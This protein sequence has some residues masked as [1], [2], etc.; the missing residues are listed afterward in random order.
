MSKM[1]AF[2]IGL[3]LLAIILAMIVLTAFIYRAGERSSVKSYIFQTDNNASQ[4]IGTLQDIDDISATVLRNKLIKKYVAEY[5]KVI[6]G[7]K[8]VMNRPTLKIMSYGGNAFDYWKQTEAKTIEEMSN[9][10]MLRLARVRDDGIATYNRTDSSNGDKDTESVY[11]KVRYTTATWVES[12]A[13]ETEPLYDQGT[14]YLE[15]RF[16]PGLSPKI[17][18]ANYDLRNYL[19]AGK[20]PAGLFKFRVINIGDNT[21]R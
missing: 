2:F 6:P 7:D 11:Y 14:L 15:V 19:E 18:G 5:F 9:K 16:E 10:K 4:R 8:N 17:E 21:R 12:N 3:S 20:N 13:L 1:K